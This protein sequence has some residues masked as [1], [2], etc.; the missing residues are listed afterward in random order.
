M[1][2]LDGRSSLPV[3]VCLDLTS[4]RWKPN[5]N[6]RRV[7]YLKVGQY[8]TATG[9]LIGVTRDD[10]GKIKTL[11]VGTDNIVNVGLASRVLNSGAATN[12]LSQGEL[13]L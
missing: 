1:G 12:T 7:P 2:I 13:Y 4:P 6:T 5:G 11:K 8:I 3:S 9:S 10:E